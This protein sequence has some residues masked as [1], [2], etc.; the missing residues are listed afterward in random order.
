ME[1]MVGSGAAV[2]EMEAAS[3]A[4]ACGLFGKPLICIKASGEGRGE[5]GG[6]RA[7]RGQSPGLWASRS[8][9]PGRKPRGR[10]GAGGVPRARGFIEA[11][12]ARLGSTPRRRG[13]R[14]PRRR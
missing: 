3:I 7:R 11:R 12:P 1:L 4:W 2:K 6:G 5:G 9:A 13:P 14:P 10:A 8:W